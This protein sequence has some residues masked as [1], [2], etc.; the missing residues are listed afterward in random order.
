MVCQLSFTWLFC[1]TDFFPLEPVFLPESI[2]VVSDSSRLPDAHHLYICAFLSHG[3]F[4]L[5]IS[6]WIHFIS[7]LLGILAYFS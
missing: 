7:T 2:N 5:L 4:A 6:C 1:H 3:V